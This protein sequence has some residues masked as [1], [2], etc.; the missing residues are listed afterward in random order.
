MPILIGQ[1]NVLPDLVQTESLGHYTFRLLR[2]D[3]TSLDLADSAG[4]KVQAGVQGLD[5]PTLD[6]IEHTPAGWDGSIIDSILAEPR[7]VFLPILFTAAD[8]LSLRA[9]KQKLSSYLNP[10][11]GPVTLR[12]G[13]PDATGRLIDGYYRPVPGAMD[14][15]NWGVAWQKIG[16]VLHCPQPFWR[17]EDDWRIT[18]KADPARPGILPILPLG[19]ADSNALGGPGGSTNPVTIQGDVETYPVW[20]ITGPLE[21]ATITDVGTGRTF[22][23]TASVGLGQ[24]WTIDTRRGRQGVFAPDGS[25]Q[26][27]TLNAGAYLFPLQPGVSAVETAVTGSSLGAQVFGT[28]PQLWLAA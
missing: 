5:D 18:W 13:L 15:E 4:Y 10:R 9:L 19:P 20:K 7:E 1:P 8:L 16:I 27:S 22:T 6:I 11:K 17:S 2:A 3:G 14:T 21:S 25:R 26:R 24:T 12:V 28:A 23:F